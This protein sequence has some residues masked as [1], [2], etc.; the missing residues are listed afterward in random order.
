MEHNHYFDGQ[1][2]SLGFERLGLRATVGVMEAGDYRFNTGA[3][4]RMTVVSGRLMVQLP[5]TQAWLTCLAGS[6]FE[7]PADDSFAVRVES[8][9]VAYLCEFLPRG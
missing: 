4:E 9:P 6:A 7:I 1:V 2:Q 5:G 8:G 3:P